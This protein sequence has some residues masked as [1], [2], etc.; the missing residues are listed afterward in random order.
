MPR[1]VCIDVDEAGNY[2]WC[3][4]EGKELR[5]VPLPKEAALAMKEIPICTEGFCEGV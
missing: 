2:A 1:K 4:C 5:C 3:W